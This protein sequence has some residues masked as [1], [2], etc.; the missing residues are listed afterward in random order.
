MIYTVGEVAKQLNV[1]ASTLRYYD[2]EGLL[3]FLERSGG[4]MRMFKEEDLSWLK[5]IECLKK[6]G[7]P[8]KDIKHFIDCCMKGD[9]KI[10]ERL[11]II[12][13]Q[14]DAVIKKMEEMQEMLDMLNF[15]VWYYETAKEAGTCSIHDP[16]NV[17]LGNIP[18]E[19]HKFIN[20]K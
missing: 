12:E 11:S 6:T 18:K 4:G 9:S 1:A 17:Q 8:I 3:P 10:D 16:D 5:T 7:M 14:R 20:E 2:K 19:Y 15:K 13:S